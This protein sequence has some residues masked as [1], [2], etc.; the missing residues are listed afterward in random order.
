MSERPRPSDPEVSRSKR[1]ISLQ[2]KMNTLKQQQAVI[3]LD[4]MLEKLDGHD[5]VPPPS[6]GE[7]K[8]AAQ[9]IQSSGR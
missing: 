2:F 3:L 1:K 4:R 6:N 5:S 8:D 7:E 9:G